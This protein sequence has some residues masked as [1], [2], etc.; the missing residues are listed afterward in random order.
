MHNPAP[1]WAPT[2]PFIT[3]TRAHGLRLGPKMVSSPGKSHRSV[4]LR[5]RQDLNTSLQAAQP[6]LWAGIPRGDSLEW[7]I[8]DFSFTEPSMT[9]SSKTGLEEKMAHMFPLA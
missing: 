4:T 8:M 5:A 2:D 6:A 1:C 3:H 7:I 9:H